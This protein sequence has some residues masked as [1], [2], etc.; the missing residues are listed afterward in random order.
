M[1]GEF[2]KE[3]R[4]AKGL[5]LREFCKMIEVDA[6]NWSKVER[7][8]LAP[9]QDPQKLQRIAQ[10]LEISEEDADWNM[11]CD[12]ASVDAGKIPP[13]L[14]SDKEVI[15]SLPIFFR[16]IGSVKPTQQELAALIAKIREERI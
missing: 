2:I 11:L 9:P 6:S 4:L 1:F 3:K 14:M 8:Q 10:I 15:E 5:G 7:E 12:Y 16:T 13:Y